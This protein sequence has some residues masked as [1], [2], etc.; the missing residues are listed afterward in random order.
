MTSVLMCVGP[1]EQQSGYNVVP[2]KAVFDQA[3]KGS[4]SRQR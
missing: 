3:R 2:V 4:G 1:E